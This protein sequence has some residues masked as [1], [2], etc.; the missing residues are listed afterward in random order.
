MLINKSAGSR[1]LALLTGTVLALSACATSNGSAG[2][3]VKD[4]SARAST[5]N[6]TITWAH[7]QEFSAYNPNTADGNSIANTSALNGVLSGFWQFAPDGSLLP[8]EDFG[9]QKKISDSPLT[10]KYTI[11]EKA[12]WSD[13]DPI[14]CDDF[15]LAWLA[16]SGLTGDKGFDTAQKAGYQDQ[17]K[18]V[19]TAG[20]RE[21]TVTYRKPYGDWEGL[22]GPG[23]VMPAHI[24]EKQAGMTKTFVDLASTPSSPELAKAIAFY[25]DGWDLN[26]GQLKK[27]LMPSSGPYTIEAWAAGQSL[28]LVA[29][30]RWWGE[31]PL[32]AKIVIRYIGGPQ[33]A[34][35]LQN[36]EIQ[37]MDPQPQVDIVKQLK[38]MGN[39]IRYST[40]DQYTFE[41]LDFN[42][43]GQFKD[44]ALREAFTKCVP[45]QQIVDNLVKPQNPKAKVFQSRF[46][47][48]FQPAYS[49]FENSVGGEKYLTADIPGAKQLLAG[50][51]PAVRIGWRKDPA[52]LNKRRADT[53]ALLQASCGQAGF[54]V[55]D[56]GTPTFF[57]TEYPSGNFD[58]AMFAWSGS[59]LLG[60][61]GDIYVTGGGQNHIKYSNPEV[62]KLLGQAISELDKGKRNEVIKKVDTILWT[63]LVTIPLYAF[64]ALF[65]SSKDVSG[66][67]YN[68]TQAELTWNVA[69]W[70]RA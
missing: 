58:V 14:D 8:N 50:R 40:H 42:F 56:S 6:K 57:D 37:A 30:P 9:T 70:A 26:P 7:E 65:A 23:L 20:G 17:N 47:Y 48:P 69:R 59:P 24:V 32:T 34:Q 33:Q 16:N 54:T 10:V 1:T 39:S 11:N 12:T 61:N 13:G 51:K 21:I 27:E 41:H 45:R 44:K 68:A 63:D 28:T 4:P 2:G 60:D 19:C 15:L 31:P 22:Y 25:N 29:N 52:Q 5:S 49:D 66:L 53:I 64:P 43:A 18:P 67:E 55:L 62:D 35:A 3:A 36:G 46:I 38:A